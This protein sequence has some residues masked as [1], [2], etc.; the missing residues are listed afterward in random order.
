MIQ[1]WDNYA[2]RESE[3]ILLLAFYMDRFQFHIVGHYKKRT[4]LTY[5]FFV[6]LQ[7]LVWGL[8]ARRNSLLMVY[9]VSGLIATENMKLVFE[10]CG[11]SSQG[12]WC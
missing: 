3:V 10:F 8:M 6:P 7:N 5:Y 4:S 9:A 11:L 2:G 12:V 1:L